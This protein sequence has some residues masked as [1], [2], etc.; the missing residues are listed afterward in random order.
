MFKTKTIT[1][2]NQWVQIDLIGFFNY[3]AQGTFVATITL[4]RSFDGLTWETVDTNTSPFSL[5]GYEPYPPFKYSKAYVDYRLGVK[6]GEFT[7][8]NI[9]VRLGIR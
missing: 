6:V 5:V 4:Q 7:S 2:A 1:G 3:S 8:G 9:N